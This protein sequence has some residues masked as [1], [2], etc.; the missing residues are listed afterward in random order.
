ML[1]KRPNTKEAAKGSAPNPYVLAV[2]TAALA[3]LFSIGGGY[4]AATLQTKHAVAE[5]QLEYR[6]AAYAAF[7]ETID[8]NKAPLLSEWLNL[9][10]VLSKAGPSD[11]EI[12]ASENR[13]AALLKK[14]DLLEVS[15]QLD[16]SFN[17]LRLHGS[18]KVSRI[19][20]DIISELMGQ[21]EEVEWSN[22]A[23]EAR[24]FHSE[25]NKDQT[26][27]VVYGW[28]DRVSFEERRSAYMTAKL[29]TILVDQLRAEILST[30]I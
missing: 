3:G 16:S 10:K 25:W 2:L 27:G 29:M 28:E 8:R 9:G 1:C 15:L 22:Y 6:A 13:I 14:S 4:I 11:S 23:E 20:D 19:C 7:L 5:K 17:I 24:L 26:N 18:K 30:G 12:Q 21:D